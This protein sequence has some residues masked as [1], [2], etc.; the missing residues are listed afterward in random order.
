MFPE[1]ENLLTSDDNSL[2]TSAA[3]SVNFQLLTLLVALKIWFM[4]LS[5]K[6]QKIAIIF[7]E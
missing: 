4:R 2:V 3:S 1:S 6:N 5:H 7:M